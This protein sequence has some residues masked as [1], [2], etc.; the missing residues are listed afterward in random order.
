VDAATR[1]KSTGAKMFAVS[2]G[3]SVQQDVMDTIA[4]DPATWYTGAVRTR[5]NVEEAAG[6]LL[7]KLCQ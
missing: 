1:L 5:N 4:S 2:I 3:D 6:E 7:D